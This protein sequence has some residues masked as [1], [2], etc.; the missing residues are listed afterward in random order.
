MLETTQLYKAVLIID[1]AIEN[2]VLKAILKLG[3]SGYTCLS[4]FGE[5]PRTMQNEPFMGSTQVQVE[6]VS[7]Q[8]IVEDIVAFVNGPDFAS[9]ARTAYVATVEV[10]DPTKFLRENKTPD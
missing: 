6:V 10:I 9:Y 5:G 3:A 8:E 7:S 1:S 2:R 4:C